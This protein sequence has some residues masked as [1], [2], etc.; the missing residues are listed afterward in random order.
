MKNIFL[1]LHSHLEV[2]RLLARSKK[3]YPAHR[4]SVTMNLRKIS[5]IA[6]SW[7]VTACALAGN[8]IEA[9]PGSIMRRYVPVVGYADTPAQPAPSPAKAATRIKSAPAK[10]IA[11]IDDLDG[12]LV[13]SYPT[14]LP[15]VLI[16]EGCLAT[17]EHIAGTDSITITDFWASGCV[18]KA[19]V[20]I[21]SMTI[22]I[23]VQTLGT[24]D[25]YGDFDLCACYWD[26]SKS[27]PFADRTQE[28]S[29]SISADGLITITSYWGVFYPEYDSDGRTSGAYDGAT[30]APVNGRMIYTY[31]NWTTSAQAVDTVKINVEQSGDSVYIRNFYNL[32]A[33][34]TAQ[35]YGTKR[36][37]IPS[38]AVALNSSGSKVYTASASFSSDYST[39]TVPSRTITTD[40]ATALDTL[41]WGNWLLTDG[42]YL[43]VAGIDCTIACPT[44][45]TYPEGTELDAS[46]KG[47][48]ADPI[49]ITTAAEWNNLA[50][51]IADNKEDCVGMYVKVANDID[52][53]GTTITPLGYDGVTLFNGDLNGAG[54][55]LSGYSDTATSKYYG[56]VATTTGSSAYIHDITVAG[57]LTTAYNYCGGAIGYLY[58]KAHNVANAGTVTSTG[59]Q[60]VGRVIGYATDSS[61][62]VS[63]CS[64]RGVVSSSAIK[65]GGVIG[66]LST[67]T[68]RRCWNEGT[69][70]SS[71][72][73][74]AGVVA[75]AYDGATLDSCY[76][77]GQVSSTSTSS[78]TYVA[79]VASMVYDGVYNCCWNSGEVTTTDGS[80][81]IAGLFAYYYETD[82]GYY[83]TGD[84]G[85][86]GT[87]TGCYNTGSVTGKI[88]AA[89]I[90]ANMSTSYDPVID[91]H[92]CYNTGDITA[93]SGCAAGIACFYTTGGTYTGC[94]NTGSVSAKAVYSGG[95]FGRDCGASPCDTVATTFTGCHNSGPVTS[96]TYYV[97]G[98]VGLVTDNVTIDSCYNTSSVTGSRA[99]GGIAGNLTGESNGAPLSRITRC[100]NSGEITSSSSSG[101]IGGI[102][103]YSSEKDTITYCFN[104][105]SI[106]DGS[107]KYAGGILGYGYGIISDCYN[108]GSITGTQN[109]GGIAGFRSS[110]G[111]VEHC[112]NAGTV[113]PTTEGTTYAGAITGGT[114]TSSYSR[115][116]Y[117][118]STAVEGSSYDAKTGTA[119]TWAQLASLDMGDGWT[120]GDDYT[121]P[122]I[123]AIADNDYAKAHAAAVI[124]AVDTDT[125][126]A[127][128]GAFY[129]GAP[130]GVT[131]A[132]DNSVISLD[133]QMGYLNA[134]FPGGTITMTATS[135]DVAV[136]TELVYEASSGI[137]SILSDSDLDQAE[138]VSET[139]YNTSGQAVAMPADGQKAIYIVVRTYG[140]GSSA[141]VKE[142]R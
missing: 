48:A 60:M 39:A 44:Q 8:T 87:F 112:Y 64:N 32:G 35:L 17:V 121:Y 22:T 70:T 85:Y 33:T 122:R 139:L 130:D 80:G 100:W 97:G 90:L 86:H 94:Y 53:T 127:M 15:N 43:Y 101:Q 111:S 75:V 46:G 12:E 92:G 128:T 82:H 88:Y 125:Y 84:P 114:S 83:I 26:S 96:S 81:Y 107:Q 123:T 120:A 42:T 93:T 113:T 76:N 61:V 18:I 116:Y 38:T 30:S 138:I 136:A 19:K 62:V 5:I 89:G 137:E 29:G 109:T 7:C 134:D 40:R 117:L 52:F 49:L 31:Y 51:Y 66:Q 103:G 91:M 4:N 58:G 99:A 25:T 55:S 68:A 6:A 110:S 142:V 108:A 133:G 41:T 119:L 105:G 72:A 2:D 131:W 37:V 71:A 50:D 34:V 59:G 141:A 74:V 126:S 98:V 77:T 56:P 106:G 135:G 36:A 9:A 124:P 67:G 21:D 47:T 132:A 104:T 20:N 73:R 54:H 3:H 79:G 11:S 16:D 63:N 27:W 102:A 129:L 95:L 24:D 140:D 45:L 14:L 118:A 23:P 69:V 1:T 78:G 28:I 115:C 57:S 10:A 65:V 13:F